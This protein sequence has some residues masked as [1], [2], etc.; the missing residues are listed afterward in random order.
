MIRLIKTS[1]LSQHVF[2]GR[3]VPGYVILSH[4]WEEGEISLG[5]LQGN[6]N[7]HKQGWLKLQRFCQF[8]ETRGHRFV[9]IDT[10]CIDKTSSAELQ[11]AI[12]SMFRWYRRAECCYVYLCDVPARDDLD[13][14]E[15][16]KIFKASKWFT[17]GWTLQELLAPHRLTFVCSDWKEEIGSRQSLS[18]EVSEVTRIPEKPL[19]QGWS[20]KDDFGG[21]EFTVAQIMSWASKRSTTRVEDT[22]YSMMG[23]FH[24]NMPLLYGEGSNAFIRLQLEI[25][26]KYDDNSLFAWGIPLRDRHFESNSALNRALDIPEAY[27][28]GGLL[29]PAIHCFE[30]CAGHFHHLERY[31]DARLFSMTSKGIQVEGLLRRYEKARYGGSHWLLPLNCGREAHLKHRLGI[32]LAGDGQLAMRVVNVQSVEPGL[33]ECHWDAERE[34]KAEYEYRRVFVPQ[35]WPGDFD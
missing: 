22:A 10:C 8:A 28:W 31:E 11:E 14:P 24:I 35:A 1:D 23:L 34:L 26:S 17:R 13:L 6:L 12:N 20:L 33:V 21:A 27:W 25:M 2:E 7:L 19:V 5:E 30:D 29:A 15:W 18:H 4:R 16:T 9:W 3:S 32:V